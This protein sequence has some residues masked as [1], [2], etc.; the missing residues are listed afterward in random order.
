LDAVARDNGYLAV[1]M[2]RLLP[3]LPFSAVH[4]VCAVSSMRLR[5]Y[6]VGTAVGILPASAV[7]VAVGAY[8]LRPG[9]WQFL[10]SLL[11]LVSLTLL[12]SVLARRVRPPGPMYQP[13]VVVQERNRDAAAGRSD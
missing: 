12:S 6:V 8:G 13:L 1:L 11:G 5:P 2:L 9:S 4:Y 3:V 7:Y 10:A